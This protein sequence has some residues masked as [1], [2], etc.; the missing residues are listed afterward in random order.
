MNSDSGEN[1]PESG[2]IWPAFVLFCFFFFFLSFM[3]FL[4]PKIV[5]KE[6]IW[7]GTWRRRS[8]LTGFHRIPANFSDFAEI[9]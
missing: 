5:G 4:G 7:P 2:E 1:L 8:G 9:R 6:Q 3:I